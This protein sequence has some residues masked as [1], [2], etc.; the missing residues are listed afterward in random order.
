MRRRRVKK[1]KRIKV[2]ETERFIVSTWQNQDEYYAYILWGNP[3]ITKLLT[4]FVFI[5]EEIDRRV[6][7]EK[8]YYEKSKVCYFP[9][10]LKENSMFIGV[11]GLHYNN[12]QYEFGIELLPEKWNVEY[13]QEVAQAII[14]YAFNELDI[15]YMIAGRN[16]DD[17]FAGDVYAKLGFERIRDHYWA[18]TGKVHYTYLLKK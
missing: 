17:E 8:T 11:C 4:Q 9:I 15:E 10:F 3:I 16:P 14:D 6:E 5:K 2:I 1:R 13:G 12:K 7:L 18:P